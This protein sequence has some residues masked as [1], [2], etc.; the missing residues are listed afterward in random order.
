MASSRTLMMARL[1]PRSSPPSRTGTRPSCAA[2]FGHSGSVS[3]LRNSHQSIP[4]TGNPSL[5]GSPSWSCFNE[6]DYLPANPFSGRSE[7]VTS[8]NRSLL[9]NSEGHVVERNALNVNSS[10]LSPLSTPVPAP[11]VN[12]P[13]NLDQNEEVVGCVL[14]ST[15]V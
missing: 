3:F 7:V 4:P 10:V 11:D 2:S 5:A 6:S 1:I 12:E 14:Y 9:T 8:G 13:L 15:L